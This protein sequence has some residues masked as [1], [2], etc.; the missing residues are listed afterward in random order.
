MRGPTEPI[1][2]DDGDRLAWLDYL[3]KVCRRTE[4]R[5]YGWVLMGND[6]HLLVKLLEPI[7]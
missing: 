7:L 2:R 6:D 1:Y 4:L 5:V 3:G